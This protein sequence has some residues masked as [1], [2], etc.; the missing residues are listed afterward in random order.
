MSACSLRWL[1]ILDGDD[2]LR[3]LAVDL[4]DHR[5]ERRR[6]PRARRTG[7]QDEP[8]R[9]VAEPFHDRGD[10]Q[11]AEAQDLVGDLPEHRRDR[12]TL[13]EGVAA[14]PG[15]ALDA[16]GEVE[17]EVLLEPVLLDVGQDR[18]DELLGLGD[19]Q[20]RVV[21]RREVAVDADH[22]RGVRRQM[23]VRSAPFD[24]RLEQL[25]QRRRHT[26]PLC[27]GSI[28]PQALV[29][30]SSRGTRTGRRREAL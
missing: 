6:L 11:L 26:S 16:E 1:T 28:L 25:V 4:V 17:L 15:E 30:K 19:R 27:F 23:E 8:A 21:E 10:A 2:V 9:L 20:R 12:A 24:E 18:V 22:R 14:E 3:L 13:H 5:R 7:H 29:T